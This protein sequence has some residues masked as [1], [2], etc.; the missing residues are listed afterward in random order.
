MTF[1]AHISNASSPPHICYLYLQVPSYFT[2][3]FESVIPTPEGWY[4]FVGDFSEFLASELQSAFV[5]KVLSYH[6]LSRN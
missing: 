1:I 4:N 2:F 3:S 6:P 5:C